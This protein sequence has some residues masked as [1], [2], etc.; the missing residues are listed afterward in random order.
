MDGEMEVL[1]LAAHA[2]FGEGAWPHTRRAYNINLSLFCTHSE[3]QRG[4]R[5]SKVASR[6]SWRT[7]PTL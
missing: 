6:V 2:A 7:P 5:E 3:R 1:C 4:G